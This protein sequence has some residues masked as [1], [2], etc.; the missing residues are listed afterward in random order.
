MDAEFAQ[1]SRPGIEFGRW[2]YQSQDTG[3]GVNLSGPDFEEQTRH[4]NDPFES[5]VMGYYRQASLAFNPWPSAVNGV[6]VTSPAQLQIPWDGKSPLL[7]RRFIAGANAEPEY[8]RQARKRFGKSLLSE[9][10]DV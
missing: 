2:E 7:Y 1:Q 5:S 3:G 4:V 8:I 10:A 9:C 6:Q